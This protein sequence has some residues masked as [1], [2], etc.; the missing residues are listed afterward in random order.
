MA[1]PMLPAP[2]RTMCAIMCSFNFPSRLERLLEFG[3]DFEEV[4]DKAVIGD[5][6]DRGFLV[7]VDRDNDLGV[8]HARKVLDRA[9]DAAGYIQLRCDDLARL[10]DLPVV[11]GV[12]R[13]DGR[14][15][16]TDRGSEFVGD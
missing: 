11:R 4:A 9:G 14:A 1:K 6:E 13:V 8:L 2:T 12:S 16:C 5:L 15:R 3:K 7:L 10:P